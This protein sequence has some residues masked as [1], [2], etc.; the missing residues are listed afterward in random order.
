MKA[1][2]HELNDDEIKMLMNDEFRFNREKLAGQ[3]TL[4]GYYLNDQASSVFAID[5]EGK[6]YEFAWRVFDEIFGLNSKTIPRLSKQ[7]F[8]KRIRRL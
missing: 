3:C 2:F 4:E 7:V 6:V 1:F 5:R 8:F